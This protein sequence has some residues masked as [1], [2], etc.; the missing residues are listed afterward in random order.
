MQILKIYI[1]QGS[2]VTRFGRGVILIDHFIANFPASVPVREF[3]ILKLLQKLAGAV[4]FGP[5]CTQSH[6]YLIFCD[7]SHHSVYHVGYIQ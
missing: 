4:C 6:L 5:P 7:F 1:S 3:G 2:V